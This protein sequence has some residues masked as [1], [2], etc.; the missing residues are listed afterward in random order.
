M[1]NNKRLLAP[2]VTTSEGAV[3]FYAY[4]S[5]SLINPSMHHTLIFETAIT[6]VGNGYHP[7]TGVFIVPESGLYVFTWVMRMWSNA[8]HGT[9]LMV[10]RA[11][12]GSVFLVSHTTSDHSV[13]GVV[14]VHVSQGDDV[15]VR[16]QGDNNGGNIGSDYHGK[17]SFAGWKIN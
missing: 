16:T 9:E 2:S 13:T 5:T 7:N 1:R 3:A 4:M 10:N 8:I 12:M 6:N 14:V 11:V 15:F 17:S